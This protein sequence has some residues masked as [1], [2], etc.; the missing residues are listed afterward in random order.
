[1]EANEYRCAKCGGVF[2]KGRPDEEA[3]AEFQKEFPGGTHDSEDV[4]CDD[5]W[6]VMTGQVPP[7]GR[8]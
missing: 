3:E 7:P 4:V 1:M 8:A 6:N 2:L 5:C